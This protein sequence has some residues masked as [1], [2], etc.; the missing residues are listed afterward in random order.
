MAAG[1]V[2]FEITWSADVFSGAPNPAVPL[3]LAH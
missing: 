2:A 3:N 1:F